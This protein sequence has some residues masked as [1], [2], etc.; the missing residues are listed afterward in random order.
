MARKIQLD[1]RNKHKWR[2]EIL[3][4]TTEKDLEHLFIRLFNQSFP[5]LE[6]FLQLSF[7]FLIDLD[8]IDPFKLE[9]MNIEQIFENMRF[10][11]LDVTA[12]LM[13]DASRAQEFKHPLSIFQL[14]KRG[15]EAKHDRKKNEEE[16]KQ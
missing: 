2:Y 9:K 14:K 4:I 3:M 16:I 6:T 11:I 13:L 5:S 1:P 7:R 8:E 10:H 15:K 12:K